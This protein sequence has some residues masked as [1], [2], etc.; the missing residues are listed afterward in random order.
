MDIFIIQDI[1][2]YEKSKDRNSNKNSG[3]ISN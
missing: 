2:L 3:Y 1:K